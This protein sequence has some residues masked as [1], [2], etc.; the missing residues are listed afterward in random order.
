M[1]LTAARR[2]RWCRRL[3]V[4]DVEVDVLVPVLV[5]ELVEVCWWRKISCLAA[6]GASSAPNDFC[7]PP[8]LRNRSPINRRGFGTGAHTRRACMYRQVSLSLKKI[9]K[10]RD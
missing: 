6:C 10:N 3:V 7:T 4:V 9:L 5:L 8:A 1:G 2:L